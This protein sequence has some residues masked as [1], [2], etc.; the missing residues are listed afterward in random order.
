MR[1]TRS[2]GIVGTYARYTAIMQF[3]KDLEAENS[4]LIS[5]YSAGKTFEK[6]DL[7][8]LVFKTATS[9]KAIWIDC[10][11]HAVRN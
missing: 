8:V 3:M 5:S 7:K 11:I 1:S 4:D 9:K 6:R 10:G 2:N